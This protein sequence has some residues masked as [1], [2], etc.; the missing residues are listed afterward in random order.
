M[1]VT[2]GPQIAL[3]ADIGAEA[4]LGSS[5]NVNLDNADIRSLIGKASS[6]QNAMSEYYGASNSASVVSWSAVV[7]TAGLQTSNYT[8][9][10]QNIDV[11]GGD[12][13]VMCY[14]ARGGNDGDNSGSFKMFASQNAAGVQTNLTATTAIREHGGTVSG[15]MY[16]TA[17]RTYKSMQ[18]HIS[19]GKS[20]NGMALWAGVFRDVGTNTRNGWKA[21]G[22]GSTNQSISLSGLTPPG[23]VIAIGGRS[24]TSS[25]TVTFTNLTSI[26]IPN[27]NAGG[28]S[29]YKLNPGTSYSSSCSHAWSYSV[30]HFT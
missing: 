6:A 10:T 1:P 9:S 23:V 29:G 22:N 5:S 27:G 2:N 24:T 14:T 15:I 20:F 26:V 13:L 19:A 16:A 3:R 17:N 30:A 8:G 18:A 25:S 4:G 11:Q 12:L 7:N 21:G 28:T